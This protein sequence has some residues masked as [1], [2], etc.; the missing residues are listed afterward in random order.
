MVQAIKWV[1]EIAPG[2][3]YVTTLETLDKYNCDFCVHGG[4]WCSEVAVV[5]TRDLQGLRVFPAAKQ[6]TFWLRGYLICTDFCV[7]SARPSQCSYSGVQVFQGNMFVLGTVRVVRF[8]GLSFPFTYKD[9]MCC[10]TI[11][12]RLS[13]TQEKNCAWEK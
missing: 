6:G 13:L 8:L 12:P 7:A 1:D 10:L 2:A 5:L 11:I 3:P 9:E 4:E